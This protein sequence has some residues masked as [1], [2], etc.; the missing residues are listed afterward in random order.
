MSWHVTEDMIGSSAII[1]RLERL[2]VLVRYSSGNVRVVRFVCAEV[3]GYE[4][5]LYVLHLA[6]YQTSGSSQPCIQ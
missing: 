1:R 2:N 3:G 5:R 6:R 4:R